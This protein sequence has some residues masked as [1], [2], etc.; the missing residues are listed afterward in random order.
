MAEIKQGLILTVEG[1]K[2]SNG[3]CMFARVCPINKEQL[4]SRPLTLP[5]YLRGSYGKLS[6]GTPVAYVVFDDESGLVIERLDG[7]WDGQ[8][9][10][11]TVKIEGDVYADKISLRSHVHGGVQNGGGKT[12]KAE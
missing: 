6:K 9:V 12:G 8:S 11:G 10:P 5:F 2:D 1:N 7:N 3:N 4:V